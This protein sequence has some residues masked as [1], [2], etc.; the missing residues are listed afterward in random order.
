MIR[1]FKQ[2]R[3]CEFLL[4]EVYEMK[5]ALS[6]LFAV[7][8]IL[9]SMSAMACAWGEESGWSTSCPYCGETFSN[10]DA[11]ADHIARYNHT[12]GHYIVCPYSGEDY[13]DGGCGQ[14]FS[15]QR[16]YDLHVET[17]PHNGDYS[18]LGWIK[19]YGGKLVDAVKNVAWGDLFGGIVSVVKALFAGVDFKEIVGLGKNII[20][21]V[22]K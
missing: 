19:Y 7:L 8:F 5:K 11:Y 10:E 15:T 9:S 17:C 20:G 3:N 21:A 14:K 22:K 12:D 6:V 4:K 18:T 13:V 1:L 16:A 2:V